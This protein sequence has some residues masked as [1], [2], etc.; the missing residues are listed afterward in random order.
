MVTENIT[1]TTVINNRL[2]Y[3]LIE[4][5]FLNFL[6]NNLTD[7]QNR[8]EYNEETFT[9]DGR[10][11]YELEGDLDSKGRH[12]IMCVKELTVNGVKQT[13]LKDYQIGFRK[14]S[15]ILGKIRFWNAPT[16]GSTIIIKYYWRYH[17][18]FSELPRVDLTS[19]SYPR[20]SFQIYNSI[21]TDVAIGGKVHKHNLTLRITVVDLTKTYVEDLIQETHNLFVEEE[22][23][24]GFHT[25]DYVRN[26]KLTPLVPN[27]EDPNDVVFMQQLDLEV[28]S[29]YEFS[30]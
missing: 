3:S 7:R 23:K 27:G 20:V 16:I 4:D 25:V 30:K 6:R 24:H 12:K 1:S 11:L 13:L 29:Q 10:I 22:N 14:E 9:A 28:P 8:A 2:V 21:P 17:F 19:D 18:I 5:E 26:P 15:P